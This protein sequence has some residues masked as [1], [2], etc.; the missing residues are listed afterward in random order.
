MKKENKIKA[1]IFDSNGVLFLTSYSDKVVRGHSTVGF[2]EDVAKKLNIEL[3]I[4]FDAI[5]SP[6][7]D[8]ILGKFSEKKTLSIIAK[9]LEIDSG[10]LEKVILSVYG[11]HFVK[12]KKIYR[13]IDK[14]RVLGLYQLGILSDQWQF[15]RKALLTKENVRRFSPVIVSCD[16]GIRKPSLEVYKLLMKELR[17]KDK[18]LKYDEVVFIDNCEYNLKPARKLG[19]KVILFKDVDGM[20]GDLGKMGIDV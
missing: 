5:D 10:K 19:M 14:L 16:V 4:W 1:I 12:N 20:V 18:G 2:H 17:K 7:A 11:R 8:S 3:D 13:V 15:S 6:Y 9:N